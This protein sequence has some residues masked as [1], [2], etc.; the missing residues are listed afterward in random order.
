MTRIETS[1][2]GYAGGGPLWAHFGGPTHSS[3]YAV[4]VCLDYRA[5]NDPLSV[6][7]VAASTSTMIGGPGPHA[8]DAPGH[9]SYCPIPA[10]DADS[11]LVQT[12]SVIL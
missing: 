1:A 4:K 5:N 9:A 10:I 6:T 2:R 8:A 11:L 7:V 12:D 3:T